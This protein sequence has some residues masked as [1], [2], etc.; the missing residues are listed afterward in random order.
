[1]AKRCT[2]CGVIKDISEFYK[3]KNYKNGLYSQCKKCCVKITT[4]Y[5]KTENGKKTVRKYQKTGKR[6]SSARKQRL[7]K[8]Y[9]ITL[10]QYDKM[11]EQ[12]NGVCM[13]CGGTNENGRRLFVD[14]DHKTGKTRSLLCIVCN[15]K[16]GVLEDKDWRPLA[17]KYLCDH[18][19]LKSK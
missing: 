13:I 17:D 16:I 11:F 14:H 2:K 8:N 15:T 18:S 7:K 19:S 6:K 3:H 1:M 9:N 5:R 10:E 4:Q 12:Q